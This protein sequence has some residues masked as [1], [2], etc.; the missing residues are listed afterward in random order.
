MPRKSQTG[1]DAESAEVTELAWVDA[2]AGYALALD[3]L[4]LVCRNAKGNRLK[5][6]PKEVREGEAAQ[7]LLALKEWLERHARECVD[8]VETWMLRSLP[9]PRD[10][11]ESVWSDSAW[12]QPLRDAVVMPL[13]GDGKGFASGFLRGIDRT[14]GIGAVTPDGETR[15]SAA[16]QLL[17]PH[18]IAIP[19]LEDFREFAGELQIEQGIAQLYRE[20]FAKPVDVSAN[21]VSSYAGGRFAQL[22]HALGRCRSLGFKVSG[23]FALTRVWEGGRMI[24]PR[25]WVGSDSPDAEA[26][27]GDLI[28]V[29]AAS[30]QLPLSEVGP[31]AYSE[32]VRMASLIYAA[33]VVEE[34]D[35]H[36]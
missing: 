25:F 2:S 9:I 7:Q 16:G 36:G 24:E 26:E 10:V 20:T 32:G 1:K 18:P 34:K 19:E 33:R 27:T 35:D 11:V 17:I 30:R 12:Q 28:W 6:V 23:G 15:W 21:S 13:D 8:T 29:D 31:V 4:Q 5:S 22:R 14:R 3:D